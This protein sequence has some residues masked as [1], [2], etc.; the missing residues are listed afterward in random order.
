M[1]WP[2]QSVPT[3]S[4]AMEAGGELGDERFDEFVE[5][6]DLVVDLQDPPGQ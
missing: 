2:A 6:G 5:G 3:P 1:N 4:S